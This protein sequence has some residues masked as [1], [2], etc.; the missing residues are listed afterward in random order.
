MIRTRPAENCPLCNSAGTPRYE[1]LPDFCRPG[2][3][4][5][6][7]SQCAN[8]DCGL[9]WLNPMPVPED[10]PQA[11]AGYMTHIPIE[12]TPFP[13]W[14][15]AYHAL[16]SAYLRSRYGCEGL[17]SV[18]DHILALF[19]HLL[20][21]HRTE[22]DAVAFHLPAIRGGR[23]LE[24]GCGRGVQLKA[25]EQLGWNT[26]GLDIDEKTAAIARQQ[27]CKVFVGDVFS[28]SY[29]P[30]TFDAV[31][32]SHVIEHVTDPVAL[33]REC[34]R[35]LKPGGHFSLVTPNTLSWGHASYGANWGPL[36]P[37]R[38][39]HLFSPTAL[40][41]LCEQSGFRITQC[42]TTP[43]ARAVFLTS[44]GV[45]RCGYIDYSIPIRWK[46]RLWMECMETL[47]WLRLRFMPD[48]GEELCLT[49][50]KA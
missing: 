46:D 23:L 32:M 10:L 28:R 36:D 33:L 37:P 6:N 16:F 22:A 13:R 35:I 3:Q 7:I 39:L 12:T 50:L 15:H 41:S 1:N 34:H 43:R 47:E 5:W 45:T 8:V 40:R 48:C 44:R 18:T 31:V 17:A 42:V 49:A 14:R 9:L 2:R 26:E 25:L 29:A 27:E 38:H 11:Y 20:P 4:T 21:G 24:I 30:G 19:M